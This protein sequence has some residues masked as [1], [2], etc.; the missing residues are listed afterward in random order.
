M[1]TR[2]DLRAP[3]QIEGENKV[4]FMVVHMDEGVWQ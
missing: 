1:Q 3:V 2:K 4:R